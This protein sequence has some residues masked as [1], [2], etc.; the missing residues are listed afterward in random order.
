MGGDVRYAASQ[1]LTKWNPDRLGKLR[2]T[3]LENFTDKIL[4]MSVDKLVKTHHLSFP[5]AETLG[6]ALLAYV[7]LAK[8]AGSITST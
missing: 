7:M 4:N 1:L 6:P 8:A 2:L 5:D 3:S